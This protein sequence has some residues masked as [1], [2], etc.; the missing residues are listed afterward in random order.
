M[1]QVLP[2]ARASARS[3]GQADYRATLRAEWI[4]VRT[5][6]G[7]AWLLAG[8]AVLTVAISTA[9]VAA[10]RCPVGLSCD[11][12]TTKLTLTGVQ[13]GQAVVAVLAILPVCNEYSTGMIRV[14][15]AAMPR[16][17]SV[18]AAKAGIVGI[19]VIAAGAVAVLGSVLAGRLIL[20]GHGFDA[21]RGFAL[22]SLAD[23]P[24][25]RAAAGAVLYLGL[26][27][28]LSIGIAA[29]VRDSAAT[30]GVVLG[31]LYLFP[32]IA[33]FVGNPTWHDRIVRY[34]P[35]A[36]LNIQA[37][38]GVRSLPITPW[39]GLGVL[40]LWAAAAM[41]CGLLVITLRDA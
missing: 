15:L 35:M 28:L 3:F 1:S 22:I 13:F 34:T 31:V 12:D 29:V 38:T 16:R 21:G 39:A 6:S 24:T 25:L 30:I 20:P 23:G 4:K 26:I 2:G 7:S 33:G 17:V 41:A 10:T 27:G 19:L 37:T 36:G 40:A 18:L 14:T 11:V 8:L 9:A 5:G 32:V